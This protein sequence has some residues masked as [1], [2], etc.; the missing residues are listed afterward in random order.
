ML[1]RI[2]MRPPDMPCGVVV[3]VADQVEVMP[4]RN[5]PKLWPPVP[6][7]WMKWS[8]GQAVGGGGS[9][10]PTASLRRAVTLRASS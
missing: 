7:N 6:S 9:A 1:G 5:A 10:R 8:V 3:G 4:G 2:A